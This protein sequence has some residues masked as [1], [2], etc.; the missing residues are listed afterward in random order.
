MIVH[1]YSVVVVVVLLSLL[2]LI[3]TNFCEDML[4]PQKTVQTFANTKPWITKSIKSRMIERNKAFHA[5]D[6][7]RKRDLQKQIKYEIRRAKD[8]YTEKVEGDLRRNVH[9]QGTCFK[10]IKRLLNA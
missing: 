6:L 2:S 3:V 10:C 1:T 8:R 9:S 7:E 4:I 5:G